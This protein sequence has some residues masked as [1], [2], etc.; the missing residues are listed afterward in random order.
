MSIV[1]GID[2]AGYGPWLGPLVVSATAFRVPP[3]LA[4]ADFWRMLSGGV[5][6]RRAGADGRVVIADSKVLFSGRRGLNWL[7]EGA[8]AAMAAAGHQPESLWSL[9][10]ALGAGLADEYRPYPWYDGA[11]LALPVETDRDRVM[12]RA[13]RLQRALARCRAEMAGVRSVPVLAGRFNRLLKRTRNKSEVAFQAVA[14]LLRR[15]R[16]AYGGEVIRVVVD[17]QGGRSHYLH[18]L[19][20]HFPDADIEVRS[21]T[22]LASKY[23]LREPLGQTQ[24]V[25]RMR[26]DQDRL[27][28]ALASMVSKYVRELFMLLFNRYWQERIEGLARTSGYP[29]D[30]RRFIAAL[31]EA[32][33]L[34][35]T[36]KDLLIR[37]R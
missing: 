29:A 12:V 23:V 21:E 30:A 8:L 19:M 34:D 24:L 28:V 22:R 14:F 11:H 16:Q 36:S 33:A 26:A 6:A 9:V 13:R 32:G 3:E 20:R 35:G 5:A 7:E 4:E 10:E 1:A 17:K 25:F 31:R 27:P 18:L 15:L 2:E 37:R